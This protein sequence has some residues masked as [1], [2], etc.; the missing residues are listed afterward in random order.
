MVQKIKEKI[1]SKKAAK[2]KMINLGKNKKYKGSE[3]K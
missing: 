2:D 3:L 1:F